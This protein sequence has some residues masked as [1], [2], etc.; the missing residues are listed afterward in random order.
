M[1]TTG[2]YAFQLSPRAG[3]GAVISDG[4]AI[5]AGEWAWVE[6]QGE[7]RWLAIYLRC[8]DCGILM[9]LWRAYG[10]NVHGYR[11]G[12]GGE[13]SPSV[14]CPHETGGAKCGFHT[15]PTWLLGFVDRR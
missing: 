14:G 12:P 15:A 7:H 10:D 5:A 3:A 2:K 6:R 9:T 1:S 8:A 11:I 4:N 13:I